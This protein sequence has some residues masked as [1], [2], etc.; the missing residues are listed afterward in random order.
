MDYI[1]IPDYIDICRGGS[2]LNNALLFIFK[3]I[4]HTK[5]FQNTS[6]FSIEWIV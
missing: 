4:M 3:Y 5:G 1:G 6:R 2:V